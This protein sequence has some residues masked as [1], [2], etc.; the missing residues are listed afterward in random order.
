[1]RT[2]VTLDDDVYQAAETLA[3]SSGKRLGQV[4]SELIRRG[5]QRSS[6][7][8]GKHGRF[9]TFDVPADAPIISA[10]RIQKILDDEGAI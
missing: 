8:P 6:P 3:R 5:L 9:A 10:G 7:R 2:T 4:I 1:M